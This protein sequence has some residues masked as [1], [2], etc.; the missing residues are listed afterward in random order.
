MKQKSDPG[1]DTTTL[2]LHIEYL[3]SPPNLFTSCSILATHCT[4][5]RDRTAVHRDL[6][7][8]VQLCT[9][10]AAWGECRSKLRDLVEDN[11]WDFFREPYVNENIHPPLLPELHPLWPEDI[12]VHNSNIRY[13]VQ[14]LDDIFDG[15]ARTG[16]GRLG[17]F[18]GWHLR[19]RP[20]DRS[21]EEQS[22]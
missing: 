4:W 9:R 17:R 16:M 20:E 8:L 6:T 2:Q 5:K 14:V 12:Q 21:E 7:M 13:A 3:Q 22:V 10:N 15:R 19:R 11:G 18:L 1:L